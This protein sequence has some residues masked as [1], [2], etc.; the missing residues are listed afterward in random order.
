L[1]AYTTT[2]TFKP[3]KGSKD[4]IKAAQAYRPIIVRKTNPYG[5]K[6]CK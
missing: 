4:I 3:Q 2:T 5:G 1:T 6:Y